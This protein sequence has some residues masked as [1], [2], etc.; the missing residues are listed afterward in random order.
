M[1]NDKFP[2]HFWMVGD[3]ENDP[4][5]VISYTQIKDFWKINLAAGEQIF[6][7]TGCYISSSKNGYFVHDGDKLREWLKNNKIE[8]LR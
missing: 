1:Q 7:K 5:W 4:D 6:A 2:V 3:T 8:G